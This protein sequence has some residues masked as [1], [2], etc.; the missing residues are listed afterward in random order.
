M[1]LF[2]AG[3]FSA[4]Q[5]PTNSGPHILKSSLFFCFWTFFLHHCRSLQLNP[6]PRNDIK[7]EQ[8]IYPS[9]DEHVS[10][11]LS[12]N[13]S[14]RSRII[15]Y[16]SRSNKTLLFQ[17]NAVKFREHY[18]AATPTEG[19]AKQQKVIENRSK[20]E[21]AHIYINRHWIFYAEFCRV[22]CVALYCRPSS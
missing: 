6:R 14:P 15:Q 1:D 2:G 16:C 8:E 21:R 12:Y 10:Y 19:I 22:L 20:D 13:S 3:F 4:R 7:A 5:R 11:L 17:Q 9:V 18:F